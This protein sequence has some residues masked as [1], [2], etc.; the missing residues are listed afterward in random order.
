MDELNFNED[1]AIDLDNLHEE[2][3]THAQM[4]YKYAKHISYLEKVSKKAHEKVKVVRSQ[5]TKKATKDPKGCCGIDKA[6]TAPVIEAYYRTHP[7][8][9]AAKNELIDAEYELSMAWNAVKAFDDR[10]NSL[11]N[12][13]KL[14]IRNYF[15]T[16]S[17]ERMADGGKKFI[18]MQNEMQNQVRGETVQ[19]QR[20]G[21]NAPRLNA[22]SRRRRK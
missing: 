13:V 16:P 12:E 9:E 7:D 15:A 14:W 1:I 18:E 11:E 17:E 10:K 5:L 8:H 6:P 4:R 22:P 3:Q 2:W 21:L 19:K 20:E